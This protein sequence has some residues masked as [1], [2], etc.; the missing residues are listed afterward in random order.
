MK[1]IFILPTNKPSNLYLEDNILKIDN[2]VYGHGNQFI[3][4][5]DTEKF[6]KDEWITDGIEVIKASSKVVEAQGLV[7]RR[8]WNKI[9][10][11]NDTS[12]IEDGVQTVDNLFLSFYAENPVDYVE[13][14]SER[15]NG[16]F[17]DVTDTYRYKYDI[18]FPQKEE[19]SRLLSE[20][21]SL[22]GITSNMFD[23]KDWLRFDRF[24]KSRQ[25][26]VLKEIMKYD[27]ELGLYEQTAEEETL[28]KIK[29]VLFCNNDA[30]AIRLLEQYG[31]WIEEKLY[32]KED[33][34][35]AHQ[36]GAI[37]AYG[38]KEATGADRLTHFENWFNT[39]KK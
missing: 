28:A 8:G 31:E 25:K 3:Y 17:C 14:S 24:V 34:E 38:R 20:F 29:S 19:Y 35:I 13:L 23:E 18:V 7:T 36:Q 22:E 1:N 4:I 37:F 26:E 21:E 32:T 39:I 33:L 30:Q 10:L 15:I 12:L 5:T 16:S 11:T 9:V 2:E 27:E 6:K